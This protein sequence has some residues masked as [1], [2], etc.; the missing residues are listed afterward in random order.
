MIKTRSIF[1]VEDNPR[2]VGLTLVA[3]E[4]KHMPFDVTVTRDGEEALDYLKRRGRFSSRP[5]G[6]P[7]VILLD[8]K[9]PRMNG[10]ELLKQIR[11]DPQLKDI[12]VVILTSSRDERDLVEGY[13]LGVNA[14]VVKPLDFAEFVGSLRQMG[15]FWAVINEPPPGSPPRPR[16]EDSRN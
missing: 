3:L 4:E 1:L 11:Q 13:R 5:G 7:A 6:N 16:M 12:P 8:I 14:Y 15:F 9:M 10:F 2:D